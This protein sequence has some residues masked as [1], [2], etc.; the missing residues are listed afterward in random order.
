VFLS[1]GILYYAAKYYRRGQGIDLD[2][3]FKQIPPE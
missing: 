3:A 1:G 2:M